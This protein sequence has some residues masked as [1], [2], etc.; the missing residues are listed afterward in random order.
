[1]L[2]LVQKKSK[3]TNCNY[4]GLTIFRFLFATFTKIMHLALKK[5]TSSKR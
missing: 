5:E 2:G 1:M 4:L 3:A